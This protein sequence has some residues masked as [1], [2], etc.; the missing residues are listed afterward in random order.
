MVAVLGRCY[1]AATPSGSRPVD[2]SARQG[3]D[4]VITVRRCT[5]LW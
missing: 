5:V 1:T 4:A 3:G 2:F